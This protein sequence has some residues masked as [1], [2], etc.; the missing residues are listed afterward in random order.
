MLPDLADRYLTHSVVE[1]QDRTKCLDDLHNSEGAAEL[2]RCLKREAENSLSRQGENYRKTAILRPLGASS[3]FYGSGHPFL[4][5]PI[6][7]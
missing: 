1:L 6:A 4:K 3:D 5:K 7:A 2:Q